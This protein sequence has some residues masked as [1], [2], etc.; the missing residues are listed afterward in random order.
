M[1]M[2]I[3]RYKGCMLMV[4]LNKETLLYQGKLLGLE[5]VCGNKLA[6]L[7]FEGGSLEALELPFYETVDRYL[8][9]PNLPKEV[10]KFY[11]GQYALRMKPVMH[12]QVAEQAVRQGLSV[13]QW[14]VNAV[15]SALL[16]D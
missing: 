1:D 16:K 14:L 9:C 10:P 12:Q 3:L 6:I 5:E 2:D 7:E 11:S 8:D 15:Q 4:E 13:N